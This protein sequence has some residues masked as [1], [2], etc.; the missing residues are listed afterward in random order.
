VAGGGSLV[1]TDS[2]YADAE[3]VIGDVIAP[4]GLRQKLF[5]ATKLESP[6]A[7][8]LKRSQTRLKTEEID[9]LRRLSR[10]RGRVGAGK[11][12]Q[13]DD[14]REA[15]KRIL[16]LAAEVKAGVPHRVAGRP[17]A[18]IPRRARQGDSRLGARLR[19]ELWPV[20]PRIPARRSASDRGHSRHCRSG[21]HGRQPRHHARS[22]RIGK[23]DHLPALVGVGHE[24]GRVE[25]LTGKPKREEAAI[26]HMD[27]AC[28]LGRP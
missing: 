22:L 27:E 7:A 6:D 20:L 13:I 8:E 3:A 5:I 19:R 23:R 9:L 4:A 11:V 1:D 24:R 12:V 10:D 21:A 25:G 15:E 14:D 17:R 28:A 16:P 26:V 2:V 18:A